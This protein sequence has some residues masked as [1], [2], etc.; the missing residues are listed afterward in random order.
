[1]QTDTTSS[2]LRQLVIKPLAGRR[3]VC[4]FNEWMAQPSRS[5]S[6]PIRD[7]RH[8][9]R[10][11]DGVLAWEND[12]SMVEMALRFRRVSRN[13]R[14]FLKILAHVSDCVDTTYTACCK[15]S[16]N[17]SR[18][19]LT[20][21]RDAGILTFVGR[22]TT[23]STGIRRTGRLRVS[24]ETVS[25]LGGFRSDGMNPTDSRDG[26]RDADFLGDKRVGPSH[27]SSRYRRLNRHKM[28]IQTPLSFH[29]NGNRSGSRNH[30]FRVTA[31]WTRSERSRKSWRST[32]K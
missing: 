3:S 5:G 26:S 19:P 4:P 7:N 17:N 25:A 31:S 32:T 8:S 23:R 12:R 2:N 10:V 13:L 18:Q 1:M 22:R 15:H 24:S 11:S 28:T 20:R 14:K 16:Q 29:D 30:S 6:L 21:E 27:R 9:M